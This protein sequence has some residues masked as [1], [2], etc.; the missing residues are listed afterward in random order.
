VVSDEAGG[1]YDTSTRLLAPYI[2][3]FIPGKPTIVIQDEP[4]GGGL[5]AAQEIYAVVEKD[6]TKIG[7]LRAS[8]MLD[9]VLNIRGGQIDPNKYEWIGNMTSDTD[10]CTF[11][12]NAGVHSFAD[13][14]EKQVLVGASGTGSH[15][16]SFPN[17]INYVLDTKMKIIPG[18]KGI[19]DRVVAMEQGELQG[20][21]GLNSSTI[22]RGY[23]ELIAGGKLILLMQSGLHPYPALPNVPLTQSFAT[24]EKQKRILVTIFSQ[25]EIARVLAA[26]PGTPKERVEILRKALMQALSDPGLIAEAKQLNFDLN[27]MSG[28]EVAE[29]VAQ[30]PNLST[31][32]KAE[33]R[34]AVG[35]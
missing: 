4:G 3:K 1:G 16:F 11:W 8:T 28:E 22:T 21:C 9:S 14:K 17:A 15:G 7:S 23:P 33:V 2:Q 35:N 26:P 25:M 20:N 27:Q 29:I 12:Y 13:L 24:T 31:E 5:R 19:A 10:L 34:A 6:G 18:Y 32:L 30:M